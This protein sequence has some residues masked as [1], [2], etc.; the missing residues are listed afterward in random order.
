MIEPPLTELYKKTFVEYLFE[1]GNCSGLYFKNS[2][3][4]ASYLHSK[5]YSV[6]IDVGGFNTSIAA[7]SEGDVVAASVLTSLRPPQIRRRKSHRGNG[8]ALE[9]DEA[10]VAGPAGHAAAGDP[11]Q[12][13]PRP[14]QARLR[15]GHKGVV[16]QGGVKSYL[17]PVG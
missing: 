9:P 11:R 3:S 14:G 13:N 7:V 8:D 5:E 4:L 1:K 6:V 2:L 15:P 10:R 16:L 17:H 12:R